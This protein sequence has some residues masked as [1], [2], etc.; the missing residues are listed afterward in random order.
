MVLLLRNSIKLLFCLPDS[1]IMRNAEKTKK[2]N[3]Q[4]QTHV[5]QNDWLMKYFEP[6]WKGMANYDSSLEDFEETFTKYH[7]S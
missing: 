6:S 1:V 3:D 5:K 7:K 4:Y 2:W